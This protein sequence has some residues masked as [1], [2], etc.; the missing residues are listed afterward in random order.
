MCH[1]RRCI[2]IGISYFTLNVLFFIGQK[3]ISIA[4]SANIILA[5]QA[6]KAS[7]HSFTH[8]NLIHT[9]IV[10]HKDNDIVQIRRN[11]INI[12]N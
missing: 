2:Y 1:N 11:I 7:T 4:G 5:H 12:S 3:I 8:D 10:C 9:N 6:V